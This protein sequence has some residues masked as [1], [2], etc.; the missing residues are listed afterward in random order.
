[1][2]TATTKKLGYVTSPILDGPNEENLFKA[3]RSYQSDPLHVVRFT[4]SG[5][6]IVNVRIKGISTGDGNGKWKISGHF[7][8]HA[9]A[10]GEFQGYYSCDCKRTGTITFVQYF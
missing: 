4:I 5:Y 8:D 6:G 1:M 9:R 2:S 10:S 7:V 3:L